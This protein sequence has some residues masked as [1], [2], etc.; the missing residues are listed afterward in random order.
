MHYLMYDLGLL[1]M[2]CSHGYLL[3]SHHLG[4]VHGN[5]YPIFRVRFYL[6]I[7][8][9]PCGLCGRASRVWVVL[10]EVGFLMV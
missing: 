1:L 8:C 10:H 5:R 3:S 7:L 6:L 9:N 2:V 4:G